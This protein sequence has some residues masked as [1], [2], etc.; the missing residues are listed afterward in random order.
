[1]T[2]FGINM[3]H[4]KREPF[5]DSRFNFCFKIVLDTNSFRILLELTEVDH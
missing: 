4:K 1:M 2:A 3:N 5:T